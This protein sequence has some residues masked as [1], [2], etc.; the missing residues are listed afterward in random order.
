MT[1]ETHDEFHHGLH[2]SLFRQRLN[3]HRSLN[4]HQ[5]RVLMVVFVVL[6]TSI[7]IPFFILGAWPVIGFLGLD[8]LLVY[9]AFRASFR[10]AR[11]YE[12]INLNMVELHVARVSAKGHRRDWRFN[13]RWVR[14]N[15]EEDEDYGIMRLSL[16]FSGQALEI[17]Q[18]LAPVERETF[19]K[20]FRSALFMAQRG[21]QFAAPV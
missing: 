16:Q 18:F 14:L 6:T 2:A 10:S 17:G 15:V 1:S 7:T 21:P 9:L 5:F 8:I 3:P 13:P 20:S 4:A 11:A 19:V 12:E